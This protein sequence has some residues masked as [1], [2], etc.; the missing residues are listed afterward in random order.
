MNIAQI[1]GKRIETLLFKNNMTQYRL[2]KITGLNPKTIADLIKGKTTDV[3][4]TTLYSIINALGIT[5]L[6]F[7]NSPL[8]DEE[9]IE[10]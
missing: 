1:I 5:M 10:V 2:V 6:E 8:F 4:I 7:W 9:N 3:K